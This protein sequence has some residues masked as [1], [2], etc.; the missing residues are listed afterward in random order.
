M[1][2]WKTIPAFEQYS[3]TDYGQVRNS[4]TGRLLKTSIAS[5]GYP[6]LNLKSDTGQSKTVYT[7]VAVL[8]AFVGLIPEGAMIL[9][10]D[11]R[12]G[13]VRLPNLGWVTSTECVY[14]VEPLPGQRYAEPG[15]G[16]RLLRMPLDV[17]CGAAT[18]GLCRNGHR[19]SLNGREDA[20]TLI[21][22]GNRVCRIC[23]APE[24]LPDFDSRYL[25]NRQYGLAALGGKD[26]NKR[27]DRH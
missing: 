7:N 6:K 5:G 10:Q 14:V 16:Y 19:L 21:W 12:R 25:Y 11:R 24:G 26:D 22:S 1:T 4:K 2:T 20:N 27:T 13:N 9:H 8:S 23:D 15:D 3:I 18:G 17:K